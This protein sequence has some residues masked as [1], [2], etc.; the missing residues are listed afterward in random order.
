ML[1]WRGPGECAKF[2]G[3]DRHR[4]NVN[5]NHR[6]RGGFFECS[7]AATA[8]KSIRDG[9]LLTNKYV[10]KLR[11]LEMCHTRLCEGLVLFTFIE[12]DEYSPEH[13]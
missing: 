5:L 11:T 13:V 2:A 7:Q 6:Q 9:K 4:G 3:N 8:K 1:A 10:A 12:F